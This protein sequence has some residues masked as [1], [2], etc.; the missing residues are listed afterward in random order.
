VLFVLL[1]VLCCTFAAET[2]VKTAYGPVKG[3]LTA[4]G[5]H[6]VWATVP[7]AAPPVGS[8]RFLSPQKLK[9]W[10][11][12]KDATV[13]TP[14]CPQLETSSTAGHK[15]DEDCL[16]L[17]VW[18]PVNH[19]LSNPT[20]PVQI[21]V[22][23]GSFTSGGAVGYSGE[24]LS[25]N[26]MIFIAI[27]YRLGALGYLAHPALLGSADR[28]SG[29]GY[30]GIQD[31][32]AAFEWV[33]E[34]IASFGGNP[35]KV[36]ISGESA[37]A[38]SICAHLVSPKSFPY[39]QQ[40]ISESGFCVLA[41]FEE[42]VTNGNTVAE[43]VGCVDQNE[44]LV[45][46]CLLTA[47]VKL[48][49]RSVPTYFPPGLGS[50]LKEQPYS[51]LLKGGGARVPLFA[52]TN[53]NESSMFVCPDKSTNNLTAA[54]YSALIHAEYQANAEILL[55]TY[56]SSSYPTATAAYI[57]LESDKTF[58]CM[59]KLLADVYSRTPS[60]SP[61]YVY[62]LTHAPDYFQSAALTEITL[63]V[64]DPK[65]LG[66]AH[67][68]ELCYL[69]GIFEGFG[70]HLTPQELNLRVTMRNAWVSFVANGEPKLPNLKWPQYTETNGNFVKLDL[71]LSV[72]NHFRA[73]NCNVWHY[74]G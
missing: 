27:N 4:S 25:G 26:D 70:N 68:F 53:L 16:F 61:T 52:G 62:S 38:I 1:C 72:A 21:F 14:L 22:H 43:A 6:I 13:E 35:K 45:L 60:T 24:I 40:A 42:A 55:K 48:L 54:T 56:P 33:Q 12:V 34:N 18:V 7:Y 36:T 32:R 73:P 37:G 11:D 8:N 47:D 23:G 2:V 74:E 65:C 66:V 51:I 57:D 9:P 19:S 64:K 41:T 39:F 44:T 10:S 67:A 59:T 46:E 50:E 31:Q 71:S 49:V 3:A 5:S 69:F 58:H 20:L 15:M 63:G 17:S 30:Y 28:A 29:S